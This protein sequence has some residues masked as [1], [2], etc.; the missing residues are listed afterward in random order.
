[1]SEQLKQR[2]GKFSAVI[3]FFDVELAKH[4]NIA[5]LRAEKNE[6]CSQS[7]EGPKTRTK[8]RICDG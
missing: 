3:K 2:Q 7:Q 1:M 5:M 8:R 6:L 4:K